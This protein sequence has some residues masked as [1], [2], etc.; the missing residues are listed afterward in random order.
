GWLSA[1]LTTPTRRARGAKEVR[2]TL[3]QLDPG[4]LRSAS[5]LQRPA[6]RRY[7]HLLTRVADRLDESRPVTA[8]GVLLAE[9]LLRDAGSPLYTEH[10]D[11]QLSRA[12]TRILGALEP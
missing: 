2:A 5:P 12:L 8:R 10:A 6:A 7:A 3:R 4:R 1:E 9:Q 11:E